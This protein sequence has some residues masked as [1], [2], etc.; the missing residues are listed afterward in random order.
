MSRVALVLALVLAGCATGGGEDTPR[1]DASV[2][3]DGSGSSCDPT[4]DPCPPDQHCSPLLRRCIPGCRSD[5]GC[6]KGKCDVANHE[7]VGCLVSG[8]CRPEEVCSGSLC[9]PGCTPERPCP[10]GLTCCAGG[11]VDNTTNIDHCGG[12]GKK[13]SAANG[14]PACT[15]SKCVIASCKTPYENCDGNVANGCEIDT[16]SN[17]NHCGGCGK[18]CSFSN[19]T[20]SCAVGVCNISSCASGFGD[21]NGNAADGCEADLARDPNNCGGCGKKPTET[22]NLRD[23]NCNGAC[24]D[25]DGCRVAIHRSFSGSDYFYT[26][27]SSEAGCCGYTVQGLN[28]FYLYNNGGEGRAPFYRCWNSGVGQHFYT[29]SSTCEIWGADKV[30]SVMGHIGTAATCGAVPLYRLAGSAG[31]LYTTDASERSSKI[32]AGWADEGIAGYVWPAPRG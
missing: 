6:A 12:C 13:C 2:S 30:E 10:E 11:C 1:T 3:T 22:C 26:T 21:C 18:K 4:A 5:A 32:A 16:T 17:V 14:S 23:D 15:A 28:Y 8:D 9:V 20:G 24:D 7:C 27:S 19:A 31:H 29:T 25:V